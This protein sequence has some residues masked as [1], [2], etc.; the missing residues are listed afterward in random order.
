VA[1]D[2]SQHVAVSQMDVP[3]VGPADRQRVALG[4][5]NGTAA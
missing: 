3:V 1:D 5:A 2:A 4:A